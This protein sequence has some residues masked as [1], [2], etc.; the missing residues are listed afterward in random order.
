ML[1]ILQTLTGLVIGFGPRGHGIGSR[2]TGRQKSWDNLD[3][4]SYVSFSQMGEPAVR[5]A[6]PYGT[7]DPKMVQN[8]PFKGMITR[9][10]TQ[11]ARVVNVFAKTLEN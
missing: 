9:Q 7:G 1:F 5:S 11:L 10:L 8:V 2:W 4:S 6:L 3:E